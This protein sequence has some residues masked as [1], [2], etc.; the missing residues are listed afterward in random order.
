MDLETRVEK[1]ERQNRRL[2]AVFCA[3]G[4][5][6]GA[7][8]LVGQVAPEKIPDVI[9]ARRF[10]VIPKEGPAAGRSV[11]VLGASKLGGH[12]AAKNR[13]GE[14]SFL[15]AHDDAGNGSLGISNAKGQEI[16]TL[17]AK[18]EGSGSL[19]TYNAEGQE[20]V[21]LTVCEN[22]SGGVSTYNAEGQE[23]VCLASLE[24]G[25][26]GINTYSKKG[27][28]LVGLREVA[29][30][31][32]GGAVLVFNGAGQ[33]VCTLDVDESGNGT[34]GVWDPIARRGQML[35]PIPRPLVEAE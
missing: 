29:P 25:G 23:I 9:K 24:S 19:S 13:D 5:L 22:R 33:T 17:R 18:D 1:L 10:E 6:V 3:L 8:L 15:V 34:L 20:I 2:K 21:S 30:G 26:G 28:A 32:G 11:V 35:T 14:V 16:V 27:Q 4:L 31:N 7:G 12:I